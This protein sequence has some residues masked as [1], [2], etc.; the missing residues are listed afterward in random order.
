M[1]LRSHHL[2]EG[3]PLNNVGPGSLED[4]GGLL[5]RF[6]NGR[7]RAQSGSTVTGL[8]TNI[9]VSNLLL[10]PVTAMLTRPTSQG[11]TLRR[12]SMAQTMQITLSMRI[13]GREREITMLHRA[14]L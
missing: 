13:V 4:G 3:N 1:R 6:H 11:R 14:S 10:G 5:V 8:L 9:K 2:S 12:R 7:G